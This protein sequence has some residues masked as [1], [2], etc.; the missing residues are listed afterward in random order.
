M[1]S[2]LCVLGSHPITDFLP[3]IIWMALLGLLSFLMVSTWRYWSA[4]EL[5]LL[6]PRS[7]ILLVGMGIALFAI[8]N[9]SKP[10][11]LAITAAYAFSGVLIRIGGL[12]RRYGRPGP[13]P[14]RPAQEG[15]I[16]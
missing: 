6:R 11:L 15:H 8:L 14:P 3:A 10:V 1:L 13:P 9:W 16:G 7:P 4:K 2:V 12:I 5:N